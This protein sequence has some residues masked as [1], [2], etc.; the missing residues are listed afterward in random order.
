MPINAI[1]SDRY[2]RDKGAGA[3]LDALSYD[4]ASGRTKISVVA[5]RSA[6][7]AKGASAASPPGAGRRHP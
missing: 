4:Y 2:L 7:K 3:D 6:T 1:D 5:P